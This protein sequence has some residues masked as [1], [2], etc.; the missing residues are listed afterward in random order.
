MSESHTSDE[1]NS[2]NSDNNS[3]ALT[4]NNKFAN[5]GSFLEMFKQMQKNMN[6]VQKNTSLDSKASDSVT[7]SN[8]KTVESTEDSPKS[9]NESESEAKEVDDNQSN[10]SSKKSFVSQS[11]QT[12]ILWIFIGFYFNN[13]FDIN[14][15]FYF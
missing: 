6:S 2:N 14:S 11:N 4:V 9:K 15:K 3:P 12:I 7:T 13:D 10:S 8:E 5:D 1:S